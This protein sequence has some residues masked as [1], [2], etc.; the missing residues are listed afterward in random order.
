MIE[1]GPTFEKIEVRLPSGD[2]RLYN[3]RPSVDRGRGEGVYAV[4]WDFKVCTLPGPSETGYQV[5]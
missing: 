3:S 1:M 2:H 4:T 5:T